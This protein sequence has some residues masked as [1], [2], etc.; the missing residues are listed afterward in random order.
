M[1]IRPMRIVYCLPKATNTHLGYVIPISFPLQH[2]L[3][4]GARII[5]CTN[6]ALLVAY[7]PSIET[8]AGVMCLFWDEWSNRA[9]FVLS[10]GECVLYHRVHLLSSQ[11]ARQP[12]HIEIP[13]LPGYSVTVAVFKTA[14]KETRCI[15]L[16]LLLLLLSLSLSLLTYLLTAIEFSLGGSSP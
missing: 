16:L 9:L 10:Y 6:S 15:L 8:G 5:R 7:P 2:W 13:H 3:R 4:E 11:R 1:T 12:Y 14:I